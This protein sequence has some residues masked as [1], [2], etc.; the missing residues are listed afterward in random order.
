MK[1]P[2]EKAIKSS[3]G[4]YYQLTSNAF[5]ILNTE[6]GDYGHTTFVIITFNIQRKFY[7]KGRFYTIP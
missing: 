1:D 3:A 6:S 2:D 4:K 5:S 7:T